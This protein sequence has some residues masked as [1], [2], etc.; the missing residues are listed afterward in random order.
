MPCSLAV[1]AAL[2]AACCAAKGVPFREPLKPTAPALDAEIRFPSR[3]VM[4][5]IV[6]LKVAMMWT[7]PAGTCRRSRFFPAFFFPPPAFLGFSTMLSPFSG[8]FKD[9]PPDRLYLLFLGDSPTRTLSGAGVGVSSLTPNRK[10]P[11]VAQAAVAADLHETF[12]VHGDGLAQIAFHHSVPLNDIAHAHYF[13][14]GHILDLRTEIHPGFLADLGGSGS[15]DSI[16]IGQTDLN[17][18]IDREIDSRDSSHCSPPA[19]PI[20]C[21]QAGHRLSLAL[22]MFGIGTLN[23][24]YPFSAHN[25]A[26]VANFL[27]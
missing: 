10:S 18:F 23:P 12:D 4:L 14:F 20:L 16:D 19:T 15:A 21:P 7:I 6:L 13:V 5:I 9:G 26:L 1:P 22:L 8:I 11:A 27:Y 24:H 17:P 2:L 25:P 3:S